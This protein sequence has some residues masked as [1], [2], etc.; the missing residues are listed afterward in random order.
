MFFVPTVSDFVNENNNGIVKALFYE[1]YEKIYNTKPN[2]KYAYYFS[3]TAKVKGNNDNKEK[4]M[5]KLILKDKEQ[6][7]S[8]AS[9]VEF[10]FAHTS[11]GVGWDNPNIFN[12]CFLRNIASNDNKKQFVGRGLRLCVNQSGERIFE[13]KHN[14]PNELERLNN[15][16]IIGNLQYEQFCSQYQKE[17]GWEGKNSNISNANEKPQPTQIKIKNDK[18]VLANEIWQK[19]K[20]K[21]QWYVNFKN[22]ERFYEDCYTVIN[23]EVFEQLS[24]QVTGGDIKG[25]YGKYEIQEIQTEWNENDAIFK[26]KEKTWLSVNEIKNKILNNIDIQKAK[27]NP[28]VFIEKAI[29]VINNK[30]KEYIMSVAEIVYTKTGETFDDEHFISEEKLSYHEN[31]VKAEKSLFNFVDC[32]SKQEE[33]FVNLVENTPSIE[34]FVKLLKGSEEKF[35]INTPIGKYTPDFALLVNSNGKLYMVFEVKS[36]KQ[37]ELSQEEKFKIACAVK[38]FQELGFETEPKYIEHSGSNMVEKIPQKDSYTVY[39]PN[40]KS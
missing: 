5:T 30:R 10:I 17:A 22:I 20:S 4:E 34:M 14:F 29:E 3:E 39:I 37:S 32:D 12:I 21:T 26:I 15:L 8:L 28:S 35:H 2:D 25:N 6:L 31:L 38:H 13:S 11:L 33:K 9:P 24:L 27:K 16:T 40:N 36:T 7:L 23:T 1:E 19:L 18:K